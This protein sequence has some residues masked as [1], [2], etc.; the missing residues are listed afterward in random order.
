LLP[1]QLLVEF[2]KDIWVN[3]PRCLKRTGFNLGVWIVPR[4]KVKL[5]TQYGA[6]VFEKLTGSESPELHSDLLASMVAAH[7]KL[8]GCCCEPVV[9]GC[10]DR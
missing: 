5:L 10:H 4:A 2:V 6:T 1:L 7:C 8:K 9:A 3:F